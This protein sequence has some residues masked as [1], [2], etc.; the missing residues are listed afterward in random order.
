MPMFA[1]VRAIREFGLPDS[2]ANSHG[3]QV[4]AKV[5]GTRATIHGAALWIF[6]LQGNLEA[7][8]TN[9]A[10]LLWVGFMDGY[11]CWQEGAPK[12][13]WKRLV[14]GLFFGVWG[15]LGLTARTA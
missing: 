3:G 15:L 11:I 1:P 10:L 12:H 5:Y 14:G 2:I 7:V 13:A 9:L 4:Y 8:D 6:Y